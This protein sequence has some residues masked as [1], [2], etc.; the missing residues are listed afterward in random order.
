MNVPL[1]AGGNLHGKTHGNHQISDNSGLVGLG[2]YVGWLVARLVGWL[3]GW[4]NGC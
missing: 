4:L 3:V 2:W 1:K